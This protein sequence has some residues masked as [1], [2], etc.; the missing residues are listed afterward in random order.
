MSAGVQLDL[1]SVIGLTVQRR[2]FT[3]SLAGDSQKVRQGMQ[4]ANDAFV[5][6]SAQFS[7]MTG[8]KNVG[9]QP[10]P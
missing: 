10:P 9:S 8:A 1:A 7:I 2:A 3:A 5:A 4:L 6:K